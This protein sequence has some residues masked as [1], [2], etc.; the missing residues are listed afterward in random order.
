MHLCGFLTI[1]NLLYVV[2]CKA[3]NRTGVI[4]GM[5]SQATVD[6]P[7][8]MYVIYLGTSCI[9]GEMFVG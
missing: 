4:S 5:S 2:V 7:K 1:H 3:H 6:D 9:T 8:S